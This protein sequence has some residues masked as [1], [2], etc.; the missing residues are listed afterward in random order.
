MFRAVLVTQWKWSRLAV[1]LGAIAAFTIPVLS[2]QRA[3]SLP[4]TIWEARA[5]LG[6]VRQWSVLYPVLAVALAVALASTAWGHDHRGRHVYALTL[7]VARGR[8]ALMR[9]GACLVLLT[10]PIA[11]LWVGATVSA[12]SAEL[13]AG[14]HAYPGQLT[15]RFALAAVVALAMIFA[16]AAGS[17]RTAGMILGAIA[18]LALV[19]V[20]LGLADSGLNVVE[21][22]MDRLFT[23]PS[24]LEVFSGRWMLIDV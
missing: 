15:A 22:V 9:L 4:S 24:P 3:G 23:S 20:V 12:A 18:L 21:P 2:V 8:F 16:I 13:P 7:P 10:I 14:L 6:V 5:L 17:V 11:A 19:Q 1:V